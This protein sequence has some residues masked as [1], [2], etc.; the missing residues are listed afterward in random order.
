MCLGWHELA[1]I[2]MFSNAKYKILIENGIECMVVEL[3]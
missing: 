2:Q 1:R 3:K